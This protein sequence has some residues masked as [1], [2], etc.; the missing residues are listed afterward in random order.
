MTMTEREGDVPVGEIH[1]DIVYYSSP[2]GNT[3]RLVRKLGGDLTSLRI[4]PRWG[5]S[6]GDVLVM[7]TPFVLIIPT[8]KTTRNGFVPDAV[9][10]FLVRD[11]NHERMVGVIGTGNRNFGTEFCRAAEVVADRFGVPI[12][13]EVELSGAPGEEK[14]LHDAIV[15]ALGGVDI[16]RERKG[17]ALK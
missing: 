1:A 7:V 4:P 15:N 12:L 8:F 3:C 6:A 11:S 5:R 10:R 2:S 17:E 14:T 9:K 16:V 13:G